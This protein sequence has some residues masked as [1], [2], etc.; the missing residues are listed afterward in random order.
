MSNLTKLSN[1]NINNLINTN[2]QITELVKIKRTCDGSHKHCVE[3]VNVAKTK[4]NLVSQEYFNE[5]FTIIKQSQYNC[6]L[7][8]YNNT[9]YKVV[10]D[11]IVK[12]SE[13]LKIPN[14]DTLVSFFSDEE[15]L[16]II[17]SQ[18]FINQSL[19]EDFINMDINQNYGRN[20]F[21]NSL[22]NSPTKIKCFELIIMSME[23]GQFSKYLNKMIKTIPNS[24]ENIIIKYINNNKEKINIPQYKEIGFKLLNNFISKPQILKNI[25]LI[26]SNLL[27]SDQKKEIFHKS[28]GNYDIDFILLI[29]EA[30]DIV[31]NMDTISR[32]V[33]KCYARPDG[34]PN[35][36]QVASIIDLLCEYGLVITKEIIIKLLDHGCCVNNLE[37]HGLVVDSEILAK[38]ATQSY[39]PYK[40]DI[41]PNTA[42]LIRECSK[43]DNLNTIKKLKEFGGI[44]TSE[45][46][47]EACKIS[48]NGR[49]IKFLIT[50]CNVKVNDN[51]INNFQEAYRIEALDVLIKKYKTQNPNSNNLEKTEK[52]T[53]ELDNKS[54]MN[55]S[56]RNIKINIEDNEIEYELKN[57]IKKFFELKK[58]TIKY[59][60][61]YELFLKYLISNNLVIGNY[62][63]IN[64]KLSD[65]LK[66]NH[67]VIMNI[68]QIHNILT[69]FIDLVELPKLPEL[70]NELNI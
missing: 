70:N 51:C 64:T 40:F 15:L 62:F 27:N 66:I 9:N 44:Y 17:K 35:S 3:I 52:R 23:L 10:K 5:F 20:N 65:L 8:S 63:V 1:M 53:I 46:L 39:Y 7:S 41:K 31:P 68:E 24:I 14:W 29:L 32:L 45:C 36:K 43:H 56:P 26:I 61:L 4:L 67:C 42:I 28:I 37:K 12:C 19:I 25:Y 49:V 18:M 6:C 11:F 57:K 38:C 16:N 59:H 33:D 34:S 30:R 69:Y 13:Q 22:I 55:V 54:T 60:E 2:N 58:K 48:K 47:E 21:I 50:E